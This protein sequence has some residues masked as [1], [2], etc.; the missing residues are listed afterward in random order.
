MI[1]PL[2]RTAWRFFK[3]LKIELSYD[4]EIQLQGKCPK[5][6]II[7]K[8]TCTPMFIAAL[9]T[10]ARTCVGMHA[11]SLQ[12]WPALS[13]T[14]DGSPPVSSDHGSLQAR[15]LEWVAMPSSR[16]SF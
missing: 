7:Q 2:R 4:P 10:I 14:M 5:K 11:K 1:Q 12:S 3:K 8:D 6:T 13:N 9:F 15:I 16:G